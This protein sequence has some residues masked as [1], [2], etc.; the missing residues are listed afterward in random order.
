[1]KN[2][3]RNNKMGRMNH[4]IIIKIEA[5]RFFAKLRY[6]L[7]DSRKQDDNPK[8]DIPVFYLHFHKDTLGIQ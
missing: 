6:E 1:M 3:S 5:L 2:Q 7:I 8:N 4:G